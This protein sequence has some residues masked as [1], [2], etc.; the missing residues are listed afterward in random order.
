MFLSSPLVYMVVSGRNASLLSWVDAS[1]PWHERHTQANAVTL[2]DVNSFCRF[3]SL[4]FSTL[5]SWLHEWSLCR[6]N[7]MISTIF[8][9][10]DDDYKFTC[11]C[12]N[13]QDTCKAAVCPC[14]KC[15][16]H[17]FSYV[18]TILSHIVGMYVWLQGQGNS[19][20]SLLST[21]WCS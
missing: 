13:V 2:E 14:C 9:E 11:S 6:C 4:M 21:C 8:S 7:C 10:I 16:S 15:A 1:R 3:R 19:P 12:T 5:S 18:S 20:C 17:V